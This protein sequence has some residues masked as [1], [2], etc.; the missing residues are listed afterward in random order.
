MLIYVP[1]VKLLP[2]SILTLRGTSYFILG[3]GPRVMFTPGGARK[4]WVR[5]TTGARP[6][7][8]L[9]PSL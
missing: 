5:W 3:P 7:T 8:I 4:E 9:F 6:H 1:V 2:F